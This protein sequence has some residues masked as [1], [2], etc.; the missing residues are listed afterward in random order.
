MKEAEK[1]EVPLRRATMY[2]DGLM[3][4][5]LAARPLRRCNLGM[6]ELGHHLVRSGTGWRLVFAGHETKTGTPLELPWPGRLEVPLERY[7]DRHRPVLLDGQASDRLW[8]SQGARP[9]T[10]RRIHRRVTAVTRR[11]F[12]QPINPHLFRDCFAT[13]I[14]IRDPGHIRIAAILLGHSQRTNEGHYNQ[15]RALEA[16]RLYQQEMLALRL[17]LAPTAAPGRG[18]HPRRHGNRTSS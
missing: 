3:L 13:S 4:A 2:R 16:G 8:I 5:T 10:G 1:E 17:Q 7:L 12:G 14:A 15:A 18:S 9:M 6:I 11:L